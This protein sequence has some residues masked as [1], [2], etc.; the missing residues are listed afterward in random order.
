MQF[1]LGMDLGGEH[2]AESRVGGGYYAYYYPEGVISETE[3]ETNVR[4]LE[5]ED[6]TTGPPEKSQ[7]AS[8][9]TSITMD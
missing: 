7:V 9:L 1:D 5:G 2:V 4:L 8:N 3:Y 6:L